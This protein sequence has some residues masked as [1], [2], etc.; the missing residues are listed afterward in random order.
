MGVNSYYIFHIIV[1]E[2][3]DDSPVPASE[4]ELLRYL[5]M[6]SWL[7]I[8]LWFLLTALVYYIK[9]SGT[10]YKS[11]RHHANAKYISLIF[12]LWSLALV[13]KAVL[14]FFSLQYSFDNKA[15]TDF[16]QLVMVVVMSFVT[17]IAP[18]IS[19]LEVK[20]IELFKSSN[21]NRRHRSLL[22]TDLDDYQL[23]DETI[24]VDEKINATSIMDHT[25]NPS[26]L[27]NMKL[28]A[29]ANLPAG[30]YASSP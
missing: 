17:D 7:T 3:I 13:I 8:V 20:F 25:N 18:V 2:K 28:N 30:V 15:S 27:S 16:A 29:T 23:D 11:E 6:G 10:P 14:S 24:L 12:M 9:Q 26:V 4:E 19:V 1:I 22:T 5:F 21:K